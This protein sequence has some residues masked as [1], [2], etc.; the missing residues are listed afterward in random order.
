MRVL[1][2]APNIPFIEMNSAVQNLVFL[3]Y[4]WLMTLTVLNYIHAKVRLSFKITSVLF[5]ESV[6]FK[7]DS[8]IVHPLR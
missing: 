3:E 4:C 1:N 5:S 8:T 2:C 6:H 7:Q